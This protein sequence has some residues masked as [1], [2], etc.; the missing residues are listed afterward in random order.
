MTRRSPQNVE[1]W[2]KR[3]DDLLDLKP[4]YKKV[5]YIYDTLFRLLQ[6]DYPFIKEMEYEQAINFF[7]DIVYLD[8]KMRDERVGEE[9]EL[10]QTLS[11]EYII[12]NYIN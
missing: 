10:K 9:E 12:N 1:Y 11:E 5:K 4:E 6:K 2:N 8:R 3:I 7:K